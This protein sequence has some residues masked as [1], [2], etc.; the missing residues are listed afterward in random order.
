[1][2]GEGVNKDHQ[3][4]LKE[5]KNIAH[6]I[7]AFVLSYSMMILAVLSIHMGYDNAAVVTS[8]GV[9]AMLCLGL[10]LWYKPKEAKP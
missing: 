3:E 7:I 4:L 1:V 10:A 8:I 9:V 2:R 6:G 5:I